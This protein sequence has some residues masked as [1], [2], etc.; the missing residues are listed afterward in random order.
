MSAEATVFIGC[1]IFLAFQDLGTAN[2][3]ATIASCSESR[4]HPGG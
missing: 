1:G 2:D 3:Y 4:V